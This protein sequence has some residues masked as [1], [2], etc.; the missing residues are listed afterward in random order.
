MIKIRWI[1]RLPA[2]VY[3]YCILC[4]AY[5][6]LYTVC[7]VC[8]V[9]CILYTVY[10]AVCTV[11]YTA[12]TVY[13]VLYIVWESSS[14]LI[15][16]INS[17]RPYPQAQTNYLRNPPF[18]YSWSTHEY[19]TQPKNTGRKT[20]ETPRKVPAGTAGKGKISGNLNSGG[21]KP[22]FRKSLSVVRLACAHPK[23]NCE[24]SRR[25]PH[26]EPLH[27]RRNLKWSCLPPPTPY[28][29]T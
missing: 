24:T 21:P 14:P 23:G 3:R 17:P 8:T 4:T 26:K 28:L 10:Y 2:I 13:T 20:A 7:T 11:Y 16:N 19:P 5:C 12:C 15:W 1:S 22:G 6:I 29:G 18:L 25:V 9:Y 27:V